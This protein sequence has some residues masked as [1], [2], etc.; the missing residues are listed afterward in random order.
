MTDV[1]EETK[2]L[3]SPLGHMDV[4]SDEEEEYND[5]S[6]CSPCESP[7]SDKCPRGQYSRRRTKCRAF[8]DSL[9]IEQ[10][11]EVK[12]ESKLAVSWLIGRVVSKT[13]EHVVICNVTNTSQLSVK[14]DECLDILSRLGKHVLVPQPPPPP[15]KFA[16]LV[17]ACRAFFDFLEPGQL[18]DVRPLGECAWLNGMIEKKE[19]STVTVGINMREEPITVN[20]DNCLEVLALR[21]LIKAKHFVYVPMLTAHPSSLTGKRL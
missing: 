8:F 20:R 15:Q 10:L 17:T 4:D 14:R 21:R 18:V 11:V 2:K 5:D 7:H 19:I 1:K 12:Q 6:C 9:E 3:A 16:K 13:T